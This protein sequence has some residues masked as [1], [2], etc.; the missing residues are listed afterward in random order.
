[1]CIMPAKV[2][3]QMGLKLFQVSTK[4]IGATRESQLDIR[5]GAFLHISDPVAPARNPTTTQLFY[6]AGNVDRTYLSLSC[7]K[8]L[9]VV[10]QDFPRMGSVRLGPRVQAA[11]A[12]PCSNNGVCHPGDTACGCPARSLPPTD[13]PRLPC[14]PTEANL[15]VLKQ[16]I[17]ERYSSSTFNT[18][19][20]VAKHVPQ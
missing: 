16:Y 19:A 15:P 11:Q 17:L 3:T 20:G 1:M 9:Y 14:A 13:Q 4:V 5:G 10:P 8:A 12:M 18:C 6:V 7:L 2:T